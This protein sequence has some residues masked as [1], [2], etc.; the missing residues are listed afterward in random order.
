[1]D[2]HVVYG[3]TMPEYLAN[4]GTVYIKFSDSHVYFGR[5]VVEER[6]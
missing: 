3:V 1:M 5:K 2:N 4:Q 6:W